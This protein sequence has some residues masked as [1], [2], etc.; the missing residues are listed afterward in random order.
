MWISF[1]Q[2]Y[3]LIPHYRYMYIQMKPTIV[4]RRVLSE[5][6][7]EVPLPVRSEGKRQRFTP[8]WSPLM[9]PQSHPSP[10]RTNQLTSRLPPLRPLKHTRR[11]GR[12]GPRSRRSSQEALD[13]TFSMEACELWRQP[14][15]LPGLGCWRLKGW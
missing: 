8:E 9:K 6:I 4:H 13:V 7:N 15:L 12:S 10:K 2:H 11:T 14:I 3:I 5:V 1:P